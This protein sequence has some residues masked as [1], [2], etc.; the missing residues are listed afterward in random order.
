[1]KVFRILLAI[2]ALA[3]IAI[4]TA[5]TAAAAG[6]SSGNASDAIL[7]GGQSVTFGGD[8]TVPA[9]ETRQG[10]LVAFGGNIT[11]DGTV[12]QDVVAIGGNVVINGTVGRDVASVGGSVTLGPHANVGRDVALAGGS[13]SRDPGAVVGRN[14]TYANRDFHFDGAPS[15]AAFSHRNPGGFGWGSLAFGVIIAI[16]IVLLGL[17]MLLFF[18][19]QLLATSSTVEQRPLESLGLGCAGVVAGLAL[20]VLFTITI[21][22]IPISLALA[23]A[24]TIAWLFG[25][26]AI[27]IVTGQRLL[28]TASRAQEL[29][30]ALLLGGLLIGILANIPFLNFFVLLIGGSVALGAVIYSRFGTR[31]P[32]LPLIGA[33]VT[34]N[35]PPAPPSPPPPPPQPPAAPA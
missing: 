6:P 26:A 28:R 21:I 24:I 10:D 32:S 9:G 17:V 18:P 8:I 1:M 14:V 2:L 3:L 20:I 15:L 34:T 12:T 33:L 7:A 25:W 4:A 5:T 22:F 35:Q 11:V 13:L 31:P 23:T 19:R 27:F 16:G 29:V 30:P